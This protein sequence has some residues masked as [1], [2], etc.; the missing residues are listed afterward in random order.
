MNFDFTKSQEDQ[1]RLAASK[2][3]RLGGKYSYKSFEDVLQEA[4]IEAAKILDSYPEIRDR[5][6]GSFI[7]LRLIDNYR[8]ETGCRW[9]KKHGLKG[10]VKY[11]S[12]Q[13]M[14]EDAKTGSANG[15]YFFNPVEAKL[16]Q[17]W[18][19]QTA[20]KHY[21]VPYRDKNELITLVISQNA[22][23]RAIKRAFGGTPYE[24]RGYICDY[25]YDDKCMREIGEE[26]GRSEGRVSQI[27]KKFKERLKEAILFECECCEERYA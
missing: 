24:E 10:A 27:L 14:E 12:L 8:K 13:C 7:R 16:V 17:E 23:E 19:E 21:R 6:L 2:Y 9:R 25:F 22:L 26:R 4:K 11:C 18:Q 1:C 5:T 3:Y 15:N 20:E